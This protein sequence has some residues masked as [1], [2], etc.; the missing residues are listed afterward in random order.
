[1]EVVASN[2]EPLKKEKLSLY[3]AHFVK[4]GELEGKLHLQEHCIF[5][6]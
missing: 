2:S 1:M 3:T 4:N 6:A 5:L